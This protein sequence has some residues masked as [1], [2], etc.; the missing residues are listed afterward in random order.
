MNDAGRTDWPGLILALLV[1]MVIAAGLVDLALQPQWTDSDDWLYGMVVFIPFEFV[2]VIVLWILRDAYKDYQTPWQA[3]KFFLIS[4]AVLAVIVFIIALFEM[5]FHDLFA[6]LADGQTWL[7][8]LPPTAIILVDGIIS[9]YFFRGD[10]RSQAAR[11]DAVADD[12][13]DWLILAIGRLPFLAAAVYA[14]LIYL[15]VRGAAVPEWIRDPG[16]E[17]F[18]EVSLLCVAIYFFGKGIL[19]AHVHT[20]HFNRSGRR[21]LGAGWIQFVLGQ[22]REKREQAAKKERSAIAKRL[23]AL[24]GED[25]G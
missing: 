16:V 7:Y 5:G 10:G 25:A 2:R 6:A 22:D 15:R 12:L 20:A 23:A 11:L 8:I 1:P 17:A 14:L 4:V 24:Q 21:L 3:V 18:R 9:L 13:E 19:F